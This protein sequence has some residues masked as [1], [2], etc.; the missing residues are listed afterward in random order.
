MTPMQR[1]VTDLAA[2]NFSVPEIC[3]MLGVNESSVRSVG[4]RFNLTFRRHVMPKPPAPI[5]APIANRRTV[6]V[7]SVPT[8]SSAVNET[9]VSLP[10]M[11]WDEPEAPLAPRP[12]TDPRF[13]LVRMPKP[14]PT[15]AE[16]VI[17]A[18]RAEL[19]A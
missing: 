6:I 14:T 12:E 13:S 7:R 10:R 2:K 9:A 11:P 8:G 3:D 17:E 16:R 15:K 18:I 4:Y 1:S 19:M 5:R